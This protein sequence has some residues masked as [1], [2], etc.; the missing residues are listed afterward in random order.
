MKFDVFFSLSLLNSW[1]DEP[2]RRPLFRTIYQEIKRYSSTEITKR[3]ESNTDLLL[4]N[5]PSED[6]LAFY[7]ED[8]TATN[9]NDQHYNTIAA[10]SPT[11]TIEIYV[12]KEE[13]NEE[14]NY[15]NQDNIVVEDEQPY[16]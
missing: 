9:N 13:K 3:K 11:K 4:V 7:L 6:G 2:T 10:V 14:E 12:G 8:P 15:Q 1:Q 5:M 16:N